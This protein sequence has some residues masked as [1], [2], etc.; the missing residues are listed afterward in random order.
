MSNY[1]GIFILSQITKWYSRT[2]VRSVKRS[3]NI[4]VFTQ[5]NTEIQYRNKHSCNLKLWSISDYQ[6]PV[7]LVSLFYMN[8]CS[9]KLILL[10]FWFI[11][12][13]SECYAIFSFVSQPWLHLIISKNYLNGTT[14]SSTNCIY[15]TTDV[16]TSCLVLFN[17]QNWKGSCV[18]QVGRNKQNWFY[19]SVIIY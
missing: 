6:K 18:A 5:L 3:F 8:Y 15:H 17:K 14:N 10:N 19:F 9:L 1:F 13:L 2:F 16:A 7:I 4:I 12:A 11:I